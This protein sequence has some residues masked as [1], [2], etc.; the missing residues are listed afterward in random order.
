MHQNGVWRVPFVCFHL[1]VCL[2]EQLCVE[3]WC[4]VRRVCKGGC[5]SVKRDDVVWARMVRARRRH[6]AFVVA[7]SERFVLWRIPVL[8]RMISWVFSY[9][10]MWVVMCLVECLFVGLGVM[11]YSLARWSQKG[12]VFFA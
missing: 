8:R 3:L 4:R 11:V 1:F 5:G 12:C 2:H 7:F 9:A 10:R 6:A